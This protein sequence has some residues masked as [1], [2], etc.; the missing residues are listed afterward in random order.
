MAFAFTEAVFQNGLKELFMKKRRT[1]SPSNAD[2]FDDAL[3]TILAAD[4]ERVKDAI[5][6]KKKLAKKPPRKR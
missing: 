1:S 5:E 3:R 6:R 4:P 2:K